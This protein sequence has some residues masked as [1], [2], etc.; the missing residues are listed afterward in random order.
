MARVH[1]VFIWV[2]SGIILLLAAL[3]L[4]VL[5]FDWNRLRPII[6]EKASEALDRPFAIEGTCRWTGAAT[7]AHPGGAA[8]S[9][10]RSLPPSSCAWAT[11]T[12]LRGIPL[13]V[14]SAPK[15]KCHCSRY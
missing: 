15:C 1:R 2:A 6:N 7:Q 13:S 9:P 11:R 5:L 8:G 4:A 3:V 12:G 14:C 10:G